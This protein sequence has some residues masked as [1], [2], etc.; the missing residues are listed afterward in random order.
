MHL[1]KANEAW[2][3]IV[4]TLLST[5]GLGLAMIQELS[6]PDTCWKQ[7]VL[8]I[9]SQMNAVVVV[10]AA[11]AYTGVEGWNMLASRYARRERNIGR[12]QG[13]EE[14]L[15]EVADRLDG[16]TGDEL[17]EETRRIIDETRKIVNDAQRQTTS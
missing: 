12:R 10:A 1:P 9:V 2:Y 8:S 3:L 17:L 5:A 15:Q 14:S 11:T 7:N 16:L 13:R 4:F 6:R